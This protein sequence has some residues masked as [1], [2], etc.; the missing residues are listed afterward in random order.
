MGALPGI[1]VARVTANVTH[2]KSLAAV[3]RDALSIFVLVEG[4]CRAS[5][6]TRIERA[7]AE[8]CVWF[9]VGILMLLPD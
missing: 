1:M 2:K 9:S 6:V 8:P 7:M 3:L 4:H 5:A